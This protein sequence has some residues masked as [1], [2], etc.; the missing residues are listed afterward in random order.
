MKGQMQ[1]MGFGYDWDREVTTCTPDYYQWNQW[2]FRRF[3]EAG[4]S[5]SAATPR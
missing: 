3:H 4:G 2:L 1:S 5:S